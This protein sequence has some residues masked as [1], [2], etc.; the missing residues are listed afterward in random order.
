MDRH[1]VLVG[2]GH[3][4]V[5]VLRRFGKS[6]LPGVHLTV[7]SR[8]AASPYSGMLPGVIAGHYPLAAAQV[9]V[10][11]L[12]RAAGA[13]F[14]LDEAT[15]LD[16]EQRRVLLAQGSPVSFDLV[17][18]DIGS[19]PA[20]QSVL[21]AEEAAVPVKPIDGFARRWDALIARALA[22][23]GR[24][25]I[26]VIGAGAAGVELTLAMQYR[27]DRALG[28]AGF[29]WDGLEFTLIERTPTIL[30]GALEGVRRRFE[31]ILAARGVKV[32]TGRRA[33]SMSGRV[34][35]F[36]DALPEDFDEIVFAG[37]GAA[38]PWLAVSGLATDEKG[39]VAVDPSL[40]STSHGFVFAAG[41][42][43]AVTGHPRP[44]AGVFAVRQGPPLAANLARALAGE[45]P[46]PFAPQSVY[47]SLVS[48]GD[49]YAVASRGRWSAEGAWVWRWKDWLDRRWIARYRA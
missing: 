28:E 7:I 15:G 20:L 49:R 3:A 21:G 1:L 34:V 32:L 17:S 25:R 40:R 29:G 31:R 37:E 11:P 10:A 2:A 5:E 42:V 13:D 27:L 14:V 4:H 46:V 16:L 39:F 45:T 36:R 26:A 22:A 19:A 33:L 9:P 18:L 43:A 35:F 38:A 44:K 12:A 8:E 23:E 48:T 30:P 24:M 41:D 6:R 47:L